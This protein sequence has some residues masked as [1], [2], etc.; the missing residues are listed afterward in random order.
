MKNKNKSKD[1]DIPAYKTFFA[2]VIAGF[3]LLYPC[4]TYLKIWKLD[5]KAQGVFENYNGYVFDFFL[6]SKAIFVLILAVF[7]L[8]VLVGENIF[9]DRILTDTPLRNKYNF[10]LYCCMA[11]FALFVFLSFLF[12]ENNTISSNGSYSGGEGML[13][14]ISYPIICLGAMNC[15]CYQKSLD[16]LGQKEKNQQLDIYFFLQEFFSA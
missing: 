9:P 2:S 11:L 13:T 16:I 5:E 6:H 4:I 7:L 1:N 15:F 10:R 8:L 12:S 3:V 14:L